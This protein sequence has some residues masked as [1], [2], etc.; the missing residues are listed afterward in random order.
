MSEAQ[1]VVLLLM[2][3][4]S[5]PHARSL[6]DK[7]SAVR[8][9][10]DRLRARFNASVSEVACQDKWQRAVLGVALVGSDRRYLESEAARM[11]RLCEEAPDLSLGLIR[12]EWL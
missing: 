8:G 9:L 1:A 2:I 4:L 10:R 11:T 5:I 12:Q 7:R 6:K 3:E